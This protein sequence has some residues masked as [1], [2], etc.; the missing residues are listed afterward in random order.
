MTILSTEDKAKRWL[1][2]ELKRLDIKHAEAEIH[3]E[4]EFDGLKRLLQLGFSD[5]YCYHSHYK[6]GLFTIGLSGPRA[7]DKQVAAAHKLL[8]KF[9]Y[10]YDYRSSGNAFKGRLLKKDVE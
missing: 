5:S 6:G 4:Q 2:G 3:V 7:T 8:R 1:E 9:P 10:K